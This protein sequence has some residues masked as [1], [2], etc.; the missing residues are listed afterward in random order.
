MSIDT[1]KSLLL[2]PGPVQLHPEVQKILSLPMIHH[3]TPEFD[4]ILKTVLSDL[5]TLFVT[6]EKVFILSSTGSGGMEA[7]LINVIRPKAKVLAIISGKFGERWAEM[8][9]VYGAEV[10]KMNVPWGS[11]AN[12]SDVE[13]FLKE[14][15]DTEIV[16]SQA[17]ET[18]TATVHPIKEIAAVVAKTKA[19]FLVDAITALGAMPLPMDEW[20]IDGLVA[21]SQKAIMLPTGLS[22][23][24]FSQKAWAKI[25]DNPTPRYYF[26]IRKESAANDKGETFFSSNVALIRALDFV[27]K[28]IKSTGLEGLFKTIQRRAFYTRAMA[29]VLG[30][31]VYS[32]NPS[33]SVTA[34]SLPP[35]FDGAKFREHLEKSYNVTVMGGQDQL[36]G[37]II[38]LGHMG[39][40]TDQD[41]HQTTERLAAG[42]NDFGF[43]LDLQKVSDSSLNWLKE[44]K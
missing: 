25:K 7:L 13:K 23:V 10:H 40:I 30:L 24:S 8:A 36:K 35:G 34:L 29:S 17:C 38:R 26:D 19:V 20:Q 18:S 43:S 9:E 42:L 21:G 6:K 16:M 39:Y 22:L 33:D 31:E 3:R 15:P 41:L 32:K 37:K 11:A 4:S 27:L 14:N 1:S 12:V 5:K 44:H 2:A 28:D